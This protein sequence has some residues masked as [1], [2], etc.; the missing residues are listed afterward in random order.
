MAAN[1]LVVPQVTVLGPRVSTLDSTTTA[2]YEPVF[3]QDLALWNGLR[4][5]YH[6]MLEREGCQNVF[7]I[8][9]FQQFE[10]SMNLLCTQYARRNLPRI[11]QK[12]YPSLDHLRSFSQAIS[13]CTQTNDTAA[14]V[15]GAT[16]AVVA[17]RNNPSVQ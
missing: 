5:E 10:A 15:W 3:T 4:N 14:L 11:L 8:T 17:V 7:A 1:S 13:S 2:N 16:Q 9:N 12:L 6:S